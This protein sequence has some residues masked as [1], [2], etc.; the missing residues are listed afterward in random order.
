[1]MLNMLGKV[2]WQRTVLFVD[3]QVPGRMLVGSAS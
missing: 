2:R 3:R 1:V